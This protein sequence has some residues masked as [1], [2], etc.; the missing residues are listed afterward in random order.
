MIM[1]EFLNLSVLDISILACC[2]SIMV[3]DV[4]YALYT[5]RSTLNFLTFMR[6]LIIPFILLIGSYFILF[7]TKTWNE[8]W[9]IGIYPFLIISCTCYVWIN[10][11]LDNIKE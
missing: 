8:G 10:I 6:Y 1:N 3:G 4:I 9:K 7:S 11:K 2:I 5:S